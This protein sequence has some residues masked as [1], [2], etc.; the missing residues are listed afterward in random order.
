MKGHP[1]HSEIGGCHVYRL[2]PLTGAV[3]AVVRDRIKPNGLA[4]SCDEQTLFVSDTGATHIAGTPAAIHAYRVQPDGAAVSYG[5]MAAMCHAG[6]FDGFRVDWRGNIWTSSADAVCCHAPD[7]ALIGRIL[8]PE[9]VGNLC[10]GGSNR[11][12]LYITAQTSLFAIYLNT[13]AAGFC[14]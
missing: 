12:R 14:R 6:F 3:S 11:N 5:R 9:I 1:A 7:G 13:H 2:D 8:I 10:F 4:F